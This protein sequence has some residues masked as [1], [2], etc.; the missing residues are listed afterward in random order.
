MGLLLSAVGFFP[1]VNLHLLITTVAMDTDHA[2]Y[3]PKSVVSVSG[4]LRLFDRI[5]QYFSLQCRYQRYNNANY[6]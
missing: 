6:W 5:Q 4:R 2:K 3:T 1:T